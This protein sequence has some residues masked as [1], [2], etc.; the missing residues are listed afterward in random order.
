[1]KARRGQAV[2]YLVLVLVAITVLM[3]MNVN[4]Y[5]AVTAKN[6]AM[7]AGDSAALAVAEWQGELLHRIGELNV[8]HLRL[9]MPRKVA[10]GTKRT[11]EMR[12]ELAEAIV[13]EQRRLAFLGPLRGITLANEAARKVGARNSSAMLGILVRH[14]GEIRNEYVNALEVYPE[15]WEG[16]WNEYAATLEEAISSGIAAGPDN[17]EFRNVSSGASL[18]TKKSFYNAV[19]G[20]SWCWFHFNAP[21]APECERLPGPEPGEI[22]AGSPNSEVFSLGLAVNRCAARDLLRDD[23]VIEELTGN[24]I[25]KPEGPFDPEEYEED[26]LDERMSL[27]FCYDSEGVW[28]RWWEIDPDGPWRFP[29]VGKVKEEFD[30]RGCAAV[31]RVYE[32]ISDLLAEDQKLDRREA[33]WTAAAK[34]FGV[35]RGGGRDEPVT[36][37]E[38]LDVPVDWSARLVPVD[39]VGGKELST[40]DPVWIAHLKDHLPIYLEKGPEDLPG[41]WYCLQL[42]AWDTV[43]LECLEF[44]RTGTSTCIRSQGGGTER[45]GTP[46]GR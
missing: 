41:C 34:P 25:E 29:V 4:A 37:L 13:S 39:T 16:A 32:G 5:L 27:W 12:L 23:R 11:I 44:L 2:L 10:R 42:K 31:C 19:A 35:Y 18:L 43:R 1:M 7:N 24:A 15:P 28:R 26:L 46:H 21:W 33:V 17:I 6:R 9:L 38:G 3:L 30:V 20:H 36:A 8:E 45:G 40:A 14:V 22:G